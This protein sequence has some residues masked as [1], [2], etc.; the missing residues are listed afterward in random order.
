MN[1]ATRRC[2]EVMS[3]FPDEAADLRDAYFLDCG[4][5]FD[6]PKAITDATVANPVVL[7]V[8]AHG[9]SNGD[10]VDVS[11]AVGMS[12]L[13]DNRFTVTAATSDQFALS[14]TDGTD[15]GSYVAGGVVRKAVGAVSGLEHLDG[16]ELTIL[17][18]GSAHAAKTV[19]SSEVGLDV[20]ASRVHA[21]YG[22]MSDIETLRFDAVM[23]DG[24]AQARTKN[25]DHVV[26]RLHESRGGKVGPGPDQLDDL[27]LASGGATTAGALFSGDREM[28]FPDGFDTDAHIFIRQ[29][30]PL[31]FS[32]LS[33]MARVNIATR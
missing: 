29:D 2:I 18:D 33:V 21:G 17:A 8:A 1:G 22:Y 24:T 26:L 32:V 28:A 12:E 10:L 23:S 5:S 13:N 6:D 14:G 9:F 15:F 20:P 27:E 7:T 19:S 16:E 4:L 11:G 31:P 30:Q 25:I 3:G